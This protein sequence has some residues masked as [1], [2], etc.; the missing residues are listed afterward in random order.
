VSFAQIVL[1]F[2]LG[3]VIGSVVGFFFGNS[4][5]KE[6]GTFSQPTQVQVN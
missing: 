2:V 6:P 5:Q 3:T 1:G 4:K